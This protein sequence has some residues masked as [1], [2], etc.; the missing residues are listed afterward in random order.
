MVSGNSLFE[1]GLDQRLAAKKLRVG[2]I[3]DDQVSTKIIIP[4][5]GCL[6]TVLTA[7]SAS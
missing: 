7:C 5:T 4:S 2:K 1:I 6:S 3:H